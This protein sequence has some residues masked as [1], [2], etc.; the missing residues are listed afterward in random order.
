MFQEVLKYK[1]K[2]V[3]LEMEDVYFK[4]SINCT[5]ILKS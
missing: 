3:N 1:T 2:I 5:A 4:G